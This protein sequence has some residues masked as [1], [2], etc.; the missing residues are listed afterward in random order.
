MSVF[1]SKTLTYYLFFQKKRVSFHDPPV[2]TSINVKK[3][4]DPPQCIRSP[5]SK[6]KNYRDGLSFMRSPKVVKCLVK[7]ME[8]DLPYILGIDNASSK[9]SQLSDI[10]SLVVE[11]QQAME[12]ADNHLL[13]DSLP[14]YP[15]LCDCQTPIMEIASDLSSKMWQQTFLEDVK[16]EINTI[17]DLARMTE[18]KIQRLPLKS[19]KLKTAKSVL[20]A[21]EKQIN[22]KSSVLVEDRIAPAEETPTEIILF[23]STTDSVVEDI[24]IEIPTEEADDVAGNISDSSLSN[25]TSSV[26][27]EMEESFQMETGEI[28]HITGDTV[29]EPIEMP[30]FMESLVEVPICGS[31]KKLKKRKLSNSPNFR[32]K[33]FRSN[34]PAVQPDNTSEVESYTLTESLLKTVIIAYFYLSIYSNFYSTSCFLRTID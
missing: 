32:A 10:C 18:L 24:I 20:A 26:H 27:L 7:K 22:D 11:T 23:S 13:D 5:Q 8:N 1:C 15:S 19:P 28:I 30:A 21:Y 25:D 2:S 33:K 16:D 6:S 9:I 3:Y 31:I 17:G 29:V 14:I 4:I 12:I 34:S